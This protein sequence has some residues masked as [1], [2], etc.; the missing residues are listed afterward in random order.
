MLAN[1]SFLIKNSISTMKQ[2]AILIRSA[3]S[4]KKIYAS[5]ANSRGILDFHKHSLHNFNDL[6][7]NKALNQTT[8]LL[9]Y[10]NAI[11][12]SDNIRYAFENAT[13]LYTTLSKPDALS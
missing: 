6:P 10:K 7:D 13:Y 11:R 9:I 12:S 5:Y 1:I 2:L 8:C 4:F 3:L